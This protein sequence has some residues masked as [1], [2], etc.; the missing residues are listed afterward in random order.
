L[1]LAFAFFWGGGSFIS[2]ILSSLLLSCLVISRLVFSCTVIVLLRSFFSPTQILSVFLSCHFVF[3]L[4][5]LSCHLLS[6]VLLQC[7]C[8]VEFLLG[9]VF[10]CLVLLGFDLAFW[11]C[12]L[13]FGLS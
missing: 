1:G 7:C 8:F 3:P 5:V 2:L 6:C 4:V 9:L 12:P 13:V 11:S 10:S